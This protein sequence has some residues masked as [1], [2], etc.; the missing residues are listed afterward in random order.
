MVQNMLPIL[1]ILPFAV[2]LAVDVPVVQLQRSSLCCR[3][4]KFQLLVLTAGMRGCLFRALYTGTGPGSRVHRDTA[5]IIRCICWG[6]STK[7]FVKS[8]LISL[9]IMVIPEGCF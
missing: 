6:L 1:A 7:T 3:R 2:H 4:D 8:S 9:I 5:P